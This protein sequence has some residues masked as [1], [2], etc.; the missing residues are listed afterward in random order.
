MEISD[1]VFEMFEDWK[2][3]RNAPS[4]GIWIKREEVTNEERIQ[5]IH[6]AIHWKK[7]K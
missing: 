5:F 4:P 2:N 7:T 3:D 6:L 1:E